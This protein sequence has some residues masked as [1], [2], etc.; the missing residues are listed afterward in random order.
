MQCQLLTVSE[1]LRL[2]KIVEGL[3]LS[4]AEVDAAA[5]TC[6]PRR[7]CYDGNITTKTSRRREHLG[8][9]L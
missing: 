4:L 1:K 3:D 8:V 5:T 6:C 7:Q 9:Q 2:W